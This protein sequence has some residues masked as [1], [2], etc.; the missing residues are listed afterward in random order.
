MFQ[1]CDAKTPLAIYAGKKYKP[2]AIKVRPVETELL[3]QFHII[4]NIKGNPLKDMPVLPTQPPPYRL[5]GRYI[6]ERKDVIDKV[7]PGDFLL[8]EECALMHHFMCLQHL[9][10]AWDDSE[11]G[12]FREDFFPPIEIP[13]IP[14]KPWTQ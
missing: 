8:L 7:H 10:F 3:S 11:R 9:G 1:F 6:E 13:T 2:V 14:Y 4:R 12:H 5:T